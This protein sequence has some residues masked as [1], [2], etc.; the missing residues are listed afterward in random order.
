MLLK[1]VKRKQSCI[2][3]K[4]DVSQIKCPSVQTDLREKLGDLLP[5]LPKDTDTA[6][7]AWTML[8]DAV[9]SAAE[10]ALGFQKHKHQD[11]FDKND[12]HILTLIE[13]KRSAHVA[14]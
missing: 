8:K 4:L 1:S 14:L 13:A 6:E 7:H 12:H 5:A 2:K 3:R 11:W 10:S 9:F